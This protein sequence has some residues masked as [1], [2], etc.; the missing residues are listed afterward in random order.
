[1]VSE[2]VDDGEGE[3]LRRVREAVGPDIPV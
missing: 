2:Q 1:M 3:L